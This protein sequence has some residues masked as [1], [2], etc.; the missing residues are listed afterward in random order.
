M[1]LQMD[2]KMKRIGPD[3]RN[4]WYCA[5]CKAQGK[6][7]KLG[8][9]VFND[10][11]VILGPKGQ[12]YEIGF[13]DIEVNCHVCHQMNILPSNALRNIQFY[14]GDLQKSGSEEVRKI[15]QELAAKIDRLVPREK[16]GLKSFYFLGDSN[17]KAFKAKLTE[18]QRSIFDRLRAEEGASDNEGLRKSVLETIAREELLPLA[19]VEK[20]VVKIDEEILKVK[21]GLL[22][23]KYPSKPAK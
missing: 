18:T 7:T 6:E 16:L 8:D 21:P 20:D 10:K 15:A 12:E 14:L 1:E 4:P 2:R 19:K 23:F 13:T 17:L 22:P 3:K 11:I 5:Y 9:F